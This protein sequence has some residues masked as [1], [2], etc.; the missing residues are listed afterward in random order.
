MLFLS[1]MNYLVKHELIT[2]HDQACQSA[3][4]IP[5]V[6]NLIRATSCWN[7][8]L[9]ERTYVHQNFIPTNGK[10]EGSVPNSKIYISQN[11][12]T[13]TLT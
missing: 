12:Q 4:S 7:K 8:P 13:E 2:Q 9:M 3:D 6:N 10:N 1:N 11:D 5:L